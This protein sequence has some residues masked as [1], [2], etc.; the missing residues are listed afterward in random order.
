[1][2]WRYD[3]D[4]SLWNITRANKEIEYY[5]SQASFESLTKH[6]LQTLIRAPYADAK[7]DGPGLAFFKKLEHEVKHKFPTMKTAKTYHK[8]NPAVR[9]PDT[10][11]RLQTVKSPTTQKEKTIPLPKKFPQGC[12]KYFKYWTYEEKMEEVVVVC[13]DQAYWLVDP[14]DL[15]SFH[16]EDLLVS[17]A[18]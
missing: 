3:H 6:D 8:S 1:M 18:S 2:R 14:N 5:R 11:K 7:T 15:I 12:L 4:R 17:C 16:Q 10:G 9:N 13:V